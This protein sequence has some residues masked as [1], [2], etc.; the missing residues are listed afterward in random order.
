MKPF[1]LDNLNYYHQTYITYEHTVR[2]TSELG[3]VVRC[4]KVQFSYYICLTHVLIRRTFHHLCPKF[5]SV[6]LESRVRES[7]M[8]YNGLTPIGCYIT[9]KIR[10]ARTRPTI[11]HLKTRPRIKQ[12]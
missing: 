9:G 5:R 4:K 8:Q 12:V 11:T 3:V 10:P 6:R 7:T 2:K 1:K